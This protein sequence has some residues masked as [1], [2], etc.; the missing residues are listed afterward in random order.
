MA[1]AFGAAGPPEGISSTW[2]R[3]S[4]DVFHTDEGIDGWTMQNSN[5]ED[6]AAMGHVL[7]DV[8]APQLLGRDPMQGEALWQQLRRLNRHAYNLSDGVAGAIDVA[9]WDIRG[10]AA[11]CPSRP[12]WASPARRS[13]RTPRRAPS[14]PRRTRCSRRRSCARRRAITASRSS[15]GTAWSGTSRAS[16]RHARRSVPTSR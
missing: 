6:G 13:R 1:E 15:S 14:S 4:F 11:G 3:Y 9:L 5:L 16:G 8:Y 7:H 12:S 2:Y 10:K